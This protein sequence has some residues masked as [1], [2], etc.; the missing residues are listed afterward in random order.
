MLKIGLRGITHHLCMYAL[1]S[2][3]PPIMK[4]GGLLSASSLILS[5]SMLLTFIDIVPGPSS[6]AYSDACV[7]EVVIELEN[8]SC[9]AVPVLPE[10]LRQFLTT[11]PWV[12]L[13]IPEQ[14]ELEERQAHSVGCI[15]HRLVTLRTE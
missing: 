15:G 14:S 1:H 11:L 5:N 3:S 7:H 12:L 8:M 6:A 2:V 13:D 9:H 4:S 10:I